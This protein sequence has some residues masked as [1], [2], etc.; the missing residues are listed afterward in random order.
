MLKLFFSY[1]HRDEDMRNE[2]EVHL[3][4]LQRQGVISSWHD[5]RITAGS[6]I[7]STIS[8]ELE[9]AQI[10]LLLISASFV[11][12]KYCYETEM[13]RAMEK[14]D[15]GSARVIPVILHP[16]D[17]WHSFPFGKLLATPTDGKPISMYANQ[18]EA[19]AIVTRAIREAAQS[20]TSAPSTAPIA[21]ATAA[22]IGAPKD[23]SSNMRIKRS[24]SDQD[25]DDFLEASY[26]Y[27]AEYFKESC[28]ELARRNP[29]VSVRFKPENQSG[30]N[31]LIYENGTRIAQCFIWYGSQ[32]FR[33]NG[34][35]Y[36][37]SESSERNS[38]NEWIRVEDDGYMLHLKTLGMSMYMRQD[39]E[40]MSQQGVA[41]LFWGMFIKPLQS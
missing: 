31:A 3:A 6:E 5:R 10:I 40:P 23:R 9:E 18:H 15:Q 7:D 13:M 4:A 39:N 32:G 22:T 35:Y 21:P 17:N 38:Y 28:E 30:F 24:F 2:L 36:S 37:S 25:R 11:A 29:Q 26:K 19:F 16:C 1:T 12:S 8:K 34:I 33:S 14:H 20:M 27:I 41:E